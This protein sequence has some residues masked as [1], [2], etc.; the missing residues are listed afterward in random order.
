MLRLKA[1]KDWSQCLWISL[2]LKVSGPA[3]E[4]ETSAPL[5]FVSDSLYRGKIMLGGE[6]ER[7]TLRSSGP[8]RE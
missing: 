6:S 8:C 5:L 4:I 3:L 2:A 7:R 1:T